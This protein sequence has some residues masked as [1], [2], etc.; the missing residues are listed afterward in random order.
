MDDVYVWIHYPGNI[1]LTTNNIYLK[2]AHTSTGAAG[3]RVWGAKLCRGAS[4]VCGVV[5]SEGGR[6]W[7]GEWDRR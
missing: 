2:T 7:R 1:H 5:G 6:V 4:G 3:D